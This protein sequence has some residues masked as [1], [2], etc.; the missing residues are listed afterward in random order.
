MKDLE[1]DKGYEIVAE[2]LGSES[3][4][5]RLFG[6]V[7]GHIIKPESITCDSDGN[8]YISDQGNNRILKINSLTGVILGILLLE[9]KDI[10]SMRWSNREPNLTL[11]EYNQISTYF[12]PE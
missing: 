10:W 2:R 11:W 9:K 5:W 12:V 4:I 6:P 7:D 1:E 3:I 8:G